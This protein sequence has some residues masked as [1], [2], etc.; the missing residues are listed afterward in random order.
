MPYGRPSLQTLRSQVAADI[1][2]ALPGADPLLRF[3]NL[4]IVG[5]TEAAM[6]NGL[7]GYI[8]YIA[9]QAVP[10]TATGEFLEGWAALKD[11][12]REPATVASGPWQFPGANGTVLPAGTVIQRGDG[13]VYKTNADETVSGGVVNVTATAMLAG[14]AGNAASG[15]LGTLGTAIAG[16]NSGGAATANITGGADVELYPSLRTRMLQAYGAPA[17]GGSKGDYARWALQVPG[18]TRAWYGGMNGSTNGTVVVYFMMDLA[19]AAFSGFPQGTNGVAAL[20]NRATAATGDQLA[21]ANYIYVLQPVTALVYAFA[22]VANPVAMT[23]NGLSGASSATKSAIAAAIDAVYLQY[24]APGGSF[25]EGGNAL[26]TV[27]LSY[28]EAAIAAV[29]GTSGFVI[30]AVSCPHGTVSP[31]SDGNITANAGYLSVRG[32]TTYS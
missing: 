24:S 8:D 5:D 31:G 9:K 19:E 2:A 25:D 6:A 30:T 29:P 1:A 4:A 28:I 11:V 23:L 15:V 27:D 13:F 22:P 17:A 10:F 26:G 21:V 12:F 20:E 7:Y 16:I 3:S 14:A 32:A 18:V